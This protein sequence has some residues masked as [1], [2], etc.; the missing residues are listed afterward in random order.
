MLANLNFL[1]SLENPFGAVDVVVRELLRSEVSPLRS[2]IVHVY[3]GIEHLTYSEQERG[4]MG[5]TFLN[6]AWYVAS[7]AH[8]PLVVSAVHALQS[9]KYDSAYNSVDRN[10]ETD[11]GISSRAHCSVYLA[12][13]TEVLAI[14]A[15]V[16]KNAVEEDFYVSDLWQIFCAVLEQSTFQ[17]AVWESSQSNSEFP[18]P[19]AYL[20]YEISAD[21]DHLSAT[22]LEKAISKPELP[23]VAPPGRL[24]SDLARMWSACVSYVAHSEGHVS[25]AFRKN[26][27]QQY[28]LFVLALNTEPHE[29]LRYG[30]NIDAAVVCQWR[31]LYLGALTSRIVSARAVERDAI[32]HAFE[33][34]DMGKRY[35]YEGSDWLE[36]ALFGNHSSS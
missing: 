31:D 28:L 3:G 30:Q 29:I 7:S 11:Q 4:L 15:G 18:T 21:F 32:R 17:K 8:Y 1:K 9:G 10:Y 12:I 19:Y 13:K 6:P 14:E 24:P 27:I 25:P 26:I 5:K 36:D 33:S 22:A 23:Q 20:L 35:V 16:E 34:L 2:A